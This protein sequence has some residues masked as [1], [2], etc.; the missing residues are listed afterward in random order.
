MLSIN[1]SLKPWVGYIT[2]MVEHLCAMYKVLDLIPRTSK[3]RR[4]G[5]RR[6]RK[7]KRK[8]RKKKKER[9]KERKE[10]NKERGRKE[11]ER[12]E[13]ERGRKEEREKRGTLLMIKF[14]KD[15]NL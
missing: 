13:K 10:R 4:R 6:R 8:E 15:D 2:Q 9:K 11:K 7:G 3:G 5:R 14:Y 12:K 1:K